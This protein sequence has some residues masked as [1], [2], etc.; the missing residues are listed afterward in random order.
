MKIRSLSFIL[1]IAAFV[2]AFAGSPEITPDGL[3][4]FAVPGPADMDSVVLHCLQNG[5]IPLEY[6]EGAWR[7]EMR[8]PS[9]YY[10]YWITAAGNR[11]LTDSANPN[12][13]TDV[14]QEFSW[15]IVP[16]GEGDIYESHPGI[17]R[18]RVRK[19][20]FPSETIGTDRELSIYTP[21][22]FELG[23]SLPV[24]YLLHGTGGDQ[25]AWPTLG[26]EPQILDNLIAQGLSVPMIVVMPNS[27]PM[28]GADFVESF[29]EI[30]DYIATHYPGCGTSADNTA[31]A[32]LSLGGYHTFH[33]AKEMPGRFG[34]IGVFSGL[35]SP[36]PEH[37][38]TII[39]E[40][41]EAKIKAL[42]DAHPS[43]FWIAI[44]SDDFLYLENQ[45]W[46]PIF[47]EMGV[48]YVYYE[49]DGGHTWQNWRR[50][51]S[52]F[53]PMLFKK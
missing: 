49:S 47:S 30:M 42:F 34:Y 5:E 29:P 51:L 7:G 20:S 32:G 19:V 4:R 50:Y 26:R 14:G 40:N 48:P 2:S 25:H 16:G 6:S 15:F 46:L 41:S 24:L 28:K 33:I 3:V 27:Y 36:R 11:R 12:K 45:K 35:F 21:A 53:A 38:G 37:Q 39:T 17:P 43:L 23:D 22:G 18:G 52:R 44:G 1:F 9:N 31:L 10:D 13:V 8:L